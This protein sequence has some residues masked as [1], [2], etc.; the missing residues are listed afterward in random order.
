LKVE[1]GTEKV[2]DELSKA[3]RST[4]L[5]SKCLVVIGERGTSTAESTARGDCLSMVASPSEISL[6]LSRDGRG[7]PPSPLAAKLP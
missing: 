6:L 2:E 5:L 1:E 3:S 7:T 4:S